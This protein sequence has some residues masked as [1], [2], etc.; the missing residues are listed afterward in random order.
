MLFMIIFPGEMPLW[1]VQETSEGQTLFKVIDPVG[2]PAGNTSV[3]SVQ[4]PGSSVDECFRTARDINDELGQSSTWGTLPEVQ[5]IGKFS[6]SA[7]LENA[8]RRRTCIKFTQD[9]VDT[10]ISAV[11]DR[12]VNLA[13]IPESWLEYFSGLWE[14]REKTFKEAQPYTPKY[15]DL[16]LA[17]KNALMK[18]HGKTASLVR[19]I[20]PG[21]IS[22][23]DAESDVG[24]QNERQEQFLKA[25]ETIQ[26]I[27]RIINESFFHQILTPFF[28]KF[29][30]LSLD[31]S[32]NQHDISFD[33]DKV[34]SGG[35]TPTLK[36]NIWKVWEEL[37]TN[38]QGIKAPTVEKRQE[39]AKKSL[40]EALKL[41][42]A[43]L[44]KY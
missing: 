24:K 22:S 20:N 30:K 3:V 38:L 8:G 34:S 44:L 28:E 26:R 9:G 16:S 27:S 7:F 21:K 12:L 1:D 39:E 42:D 13:K 17:E 41:L 40:S 36:V 43:V 11:M 35:L 31:P 37:M 5:K 18:E 19:G 4:R 6:I 29:A 25:S 33:S 23:S 32:D 10:V 15:Q 2:S 14:D